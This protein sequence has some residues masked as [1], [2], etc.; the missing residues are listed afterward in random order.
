MSMSDIS[1]VELTCADHVARI[2]INRPD[3]RNALSLPTLLCMRQVLLEVS[4]RKDIWVVTFTGAGD[5]AFC[6]GA[7]LKERRGMNEQQVAEF[8]DN[9]RGTMND[10]ANLPQPTL[11]IINGHAF[12]GGCE[13]ALA[14]DLRILNASALIG[15]T[16]TSLAIIPGAGGCVRLPRLVGVAKAK[17]MILLSKRMTADEALNC[18]LVNQISEF[19]TLDAA[20]EGI[21]QNLLA[22]GPLAL[23]AAKAA[24]DLG[25]D[26]ELEAALKQEA[27]CYA[28]I[29]PTGD[30]LEALAAFSEK[31]KPSF[32]GQ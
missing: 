5:K 23:Q 26:L 14:C 7:D 13:M 17:E 21:V 2:T 31:R 3:S 16:E 12:G 11:A 20:A 6:A 1:L 32:K 10:I 28:R 9:I 19:N 24:I 29:I 25:S 8:V 27:D 22:N 15:L 18:G 30:R 4:Q